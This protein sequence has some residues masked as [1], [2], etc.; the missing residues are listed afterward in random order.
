[1][2]H[3]C[4]ADSE[5]DW[6]EGSEQCAW[7]EKCLVSVDRKKQPWLIFSANRVLG[8]SSKS[9]LTS[10]SV[11]GVVVA[12]NDIVLICKAF[13]ATAHNLLYLRF[14]AEMMLMRKFR[15]EIQK[16]ALMVSWCVIGPHKSPYTKSRGEVDLAFAFFGNGALLCLPIKQTSQ[17]CVVCLMVGLDKGNAI[18]VLSFWL[19]AW[20]FSLG[21]IISHKPFALEEMSTELVMAVSSVAIFV[22]KETPDETSLKSLTEQDETVC[23]KAC[24]DFF[25]E[26]AVHCKEL[27][28]FKY[29]HDMVR[30][31]LSNICRRAE[32]F[33]K[34][35]APVNF[36]TDPLDGRF[37]LRPAN[38]LV[39][40]WVGGK[41]ACVD[42]T[43]VSPLVGLS[44]RGFTAGQAALKA[45]LGKVTKH[46]K[47]CIENQHVFIP[48]AFD[49]FGF[50]APEAVELL[51]R[52]QRVM[53]NNVMTPR[54]TD[55]V[56]KRIGFAIQKELAAQLVARLP[57][58]TM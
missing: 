42:L 51:S 39:F 14:M 22:A 16:D 37:T 50:L 36:L 18:A 56:F 57:S 53:H 29:R 43:G 1:M 55:V 15:T 12:I 21:S 25:G 34:K 24:L 3:F 28:R 35:E 20:V 46:E 41:H 11:I 38:V 49:T 23:R 19:S 2:F 33:T 7:I 4:I 6:R 40:S 26:H 48:F 10:E 31:V 8:Y 45:V 9:W 44:S 47:A 32:I 27:P 30:D 58:T 52:V 5:H 13:E 17:I 54:S